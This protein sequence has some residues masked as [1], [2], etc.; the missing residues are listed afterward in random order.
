MLLGA[1]LAQR[2]TVHFQGYPGLLWCNFPSS[3]LFPVKNFPGENYMHTVLRI[4]T[5][6]PL[7]CH[8]TLLV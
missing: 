6:S 7:P 4:G 2:N 5:F 3:S 1:V 8:N